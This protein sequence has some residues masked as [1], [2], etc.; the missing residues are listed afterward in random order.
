MGELTFD[1]YIDAIRVAQVVY[2]KAG[3]TQSTWAHA[4][5]PLRNINLQFGSDG[6]AR[7]VHGTMSAGDWIFIFQSTELPNVVTLDGHLVDWS[8]LVILPPRHHFTFVVSVPVSW[9]AVSVP[10]PTAEKV[11]SSTGN[12]LGNGRLTA[13]VPEFSMRQLVKLAH[14]SRSIAADGQ[15]GKDAIETALLSKLTAMME[16]AAVQ[17]RPHNSASSAE[18]IICDALTY[19]VGKEADN[20]HV[21]DLTDA[22]QVEYRTLLR[23]FQRYLQIT[24]KRYLKL[25]QLNLVRRAL[26][27]QETSSA[28]DIMADFGVTEFGRFANDYKRLFHELPSETLRRGASK[29]ASAMKPSANDSAQIQVKTQQLWTM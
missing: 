19:V 11:L 14:D 20:I 26:N 3:P 18:K 17:S 6:S 7:I 1:G 10:T 9:I 4:W 27:A 29:T 24:P 22:A 25:R 28:T 21:E 12:A 23:A 5:C 2:L 15:Q 8:E 13:K 16:T